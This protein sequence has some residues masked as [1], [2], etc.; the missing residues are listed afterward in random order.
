[1]VSE[2]FFLIFP[3]GLDRDVHT[4]STGLAIDLDLFSTRAANYGDRICQ[5]PYMVSVDSNKTTVEGI[6][7]DS[8]RQQGP[9]T[10]ILYVN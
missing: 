2:V 1:M 6:Q 4:T 3:S 10:P 9:T 5:P 8:R 7:L